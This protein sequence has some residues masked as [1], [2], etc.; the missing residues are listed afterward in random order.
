VRRK[1]NKNIKKEVKFNHTK[2][3]VDV[4]QGLATDDDGDDDIDSYS[5]MAMMMTMTATRRQAGSLMAEQR[6]GQ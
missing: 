6:A 4:L 2:R 3:K 5:M 1:G